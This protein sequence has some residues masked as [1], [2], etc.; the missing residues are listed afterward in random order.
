[1]CKEELKQQNEQINTDKWLAKGFAKWFQTHVRSLALDQLPHDFL[2]CV[3]HPGLFV[4]IGELHVQG[5]AS[6]DMFAL[7]SLP[8]R[9]VRKY[10]ACIVD[11][12]RYHTVDR[13][14]NRKTQNS[15]IVSEGEH[16]KEYIDFYGQLRDIIHLQYNSSG[17]I[18]RSVVLFRCDWFDLG[19][20]KTGVNDDGHFKSINTGRFWYKNDPYIL[21]SQATKCFYVPDTGLRGNWQ[22]VQKFQHRHLWSVTEN[23]MEKGPSGG[24]L[25][26]QDEDMEEVPIRAN[27]SNVRSRLRRDRQSVLVD[28]AVVERIKKRRKEVVDEHDGEDGEENQTDHTMFQYCEDDEENRAGHRVSRFDIE[29]DE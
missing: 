3:T 20:K 6:A 17:G 2:L 7:A 16:E 22:V 27:E 11:G 23:E 10:S 15:G 13:E 25:T 8:D 4:Q 26:Y 28:A 29:D 5:N 9:R 21:T 24:G 19:G 18:H 14:K 12:V 1:L